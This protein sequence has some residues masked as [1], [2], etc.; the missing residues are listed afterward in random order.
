M[1]KTFEK[2]EDALRKKM[3]LERCHLEQ[4]TNMNVERNDTSLSDL[5]WNLLVQK[6]QITR[7]LS[8]VKVLCPQSGSPRI[9]LKDFCSC[10]VIC[11]QTSS[12]ETCG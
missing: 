5:G 7:L 4:R 1:K 2:T 9:S 12:A 8:S 11:K 6:N 3:C 10:L